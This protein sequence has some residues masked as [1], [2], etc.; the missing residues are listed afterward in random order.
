DGIQV[1]LITYNT[2]I[3]GFAKKGDMKNAMRTFNQMQRDGIQPDSITYK[4]LLNG[5]IVSSDFNLGKRLHLEAIHKV[6]DITG[7]SRLLIK[8]YA[9]CKSIEE[10]KKVF[11]N[12]PKDKMDVTVWNAM[13]AAYG[14]NGFGREALDLFKRMKDEGYQL[15]D[16]TF[17]S[18][19][20][21]CGQSGLIEE[22]I[23]LFNSMKTK[24]KVQ[25]NVM[26]YTCLVDALG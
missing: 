5:C 18:I 21:A 1:D 15:D 9:K 13:I 6:Q 25:P 8:L 12:V 17:T 3:N 11:E 16:G 22:T 2:I 26:H 24:Y 14:S 10:A 19:L 4:M 7:I 20:Q 23:N